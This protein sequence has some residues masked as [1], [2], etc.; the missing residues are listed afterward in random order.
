M[1]NFNWCKFSEL[2]VEQLYAVL[3]L[4]SDIFV[5]EQHCVYLD[6]DGKDIFALHLLGIEN[7]SLVAYIR[8]FPPNDIENYIVFGRVVTARLARTKGYG[9]KLMQELL[10][11]CHTNFPGISLK[12]SAQHY[13]QK[14]YEGFGFRAYGEIYEED[15]IPHIAMQLAI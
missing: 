8:L 13:L 10:S 15:G 4:R 12:C 1:L 11:Y 9:K 6:P 7:N 2:T 5:V 14:F 3:A